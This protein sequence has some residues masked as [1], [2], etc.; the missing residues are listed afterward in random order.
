MSSSIFSDQILILEKLQA[1]SEF[2][3]TLDNIITACTSTLREGGKILLAGNGGSAADAQHIAGEFVS[4]FNLER[5]GLAAIALTTDTSILTS[6]SNDY[7]YSKVFERQI[8][9]LG[10]EGDVY[11][12]YSTSGNSPNIINSLK[13][14]QDK[15]I[16]TV[17]MTGNRKGNMT[18]LC[19]FL[20]EVPSSSTPRIQEV[21][22]AI[23]HHIC[24]N[25]EINIFG[26]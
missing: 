11:I 15:K 7:G 23:G 26:N 5:K 16:I 12:A 6:I 19:D 17:G 9:A 18:H 24:E 1:D 8:E 22:A 25:V 21:H 10:C 3:I 20:I 13:K 14:A 4:K 2:L